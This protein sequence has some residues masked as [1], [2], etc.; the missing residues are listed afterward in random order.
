MAKKWGVPAI[1]GAA[2][3]STFVEANVLTFD[4]LDPETGRLQSVP[5]NGTITPL[6]TIIAIPATPAPATG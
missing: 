6:P 3:I 4:K 5:A 1:P 2:A